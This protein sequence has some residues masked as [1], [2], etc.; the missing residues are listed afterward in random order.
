MGCVAP[1]LSLQIAEPLALALT[2]NATMASGSGSLDGTATA[3]VS[4]GVSPYQYAWSGPTS[5]TDSMAVYLDGGWYTVLVT[6][7]NGCSIS[8]SVFVDVLGLSNLTVF[9]LEV[10]PNPSNGLFQLSLA[11]EKLEVFDLQGRF[12]CQFE[13]AQVLDLRHLASGTYQLVSTIG[14]RTQFLRVVKQ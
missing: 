11:V 6:D 2:L 14:Q 8:D 7:A 9:N 12:I 1:N 13:A 10:Y 4:G 5:Q 3:T